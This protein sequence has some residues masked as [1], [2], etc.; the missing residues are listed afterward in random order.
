MEVVSDEP[1]VHDTLN[2]MTAGAEQVDTPKAARPPMTIP[3]HGTFMRAAIPWS[4][5]RKLVMA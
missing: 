1:N 3:S 2:P 5:A 4:Y